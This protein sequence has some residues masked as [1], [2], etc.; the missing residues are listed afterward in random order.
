MA[1]SLP[2]LPYAETA[3]EPH[4]S[5]ETLSL[6]HGKHHKTYVETLNELVAGTPY[7]QMTL[8]QIVERTAGKKAEQKLFNNAAQ[9]WN[10]E[11]FFNSLSPDAPRGPGQKLGA[12]I[13]RDFGSLDEFKEKFHAA[14]LAQFDSGWA[15]LVQRDGKLA[16]LTTGNADNPI[17]TGGAALLACDVWEH[18][19]YLDHR[20][21]RDEFV[22][23]FLDKL[24]NWRFA[25]K[26]LA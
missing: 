14:A 25:E 7:E 26:Q 6:H 15:W 22:T 20:N 19:Y 12:L 11:F 18:A 1:F 17:S 9:A 21:R 2:P 3:L 13:A 4:M 8:S 10:H 16:V 5:A 23:A 24:A